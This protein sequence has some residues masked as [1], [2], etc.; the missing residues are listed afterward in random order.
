[1]F[2]TCLRANREGMELLERAL[3]DDPTHIESLWRY[4]KG[5]FRLSLFAKARYCGCFND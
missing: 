4:A 5:L 1:M 3:Q 2:V